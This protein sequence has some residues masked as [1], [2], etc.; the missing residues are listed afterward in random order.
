MNGKIPSPIFK[1]VV[2]KRGHRDC[3]SAVGRYCFTKELS[4]DCFEKQD[5]GAFTRAHG[6][7]DVL[8]SWLVFSL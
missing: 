4:M 3:M 5:N 1:Y 2:D 8:L 7:M 6:A